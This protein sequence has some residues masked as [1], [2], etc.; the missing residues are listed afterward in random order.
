MSR[1]IVRPTFTSAAML[2]N[3]DWYARSPEAPMMLHVKNQFRIL[4]RLLIE[5]AALAAMS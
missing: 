1:E 4:K 3:V 2:V 5:N